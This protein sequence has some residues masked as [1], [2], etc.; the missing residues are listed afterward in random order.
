M[1]IRNSLSHLFLILFLTLCLVAFGAFGCGDDDDDDDTGNLPP[2]DDDD[3]DDDDDSAVSPVSVEIVGNLEM[4]P[5]TTTVEYSALV[6]YS[7]DTT[8]TNPADLEW[9][10]ENEDVAT[11]VDGTVTGVA[12]GATTL[13]AAVG[14]TKVSGSMDIFVGPDVYL[15]DFFTNTFDA[16][17]RV[18]KTYT[19]GYID[20]AGPDEM[21]LNDIIFADGKVYLANSGDFFLGTEGDEGVFEVDTGN[22]TT[23]LI[24]IAVTGPWATANDNGTIYLTGNG[25]SKLGIYNSTKGVSFVDLPA[26]CVP[27]EL[28][29]ANGKVYI[30]CTGFDFSDF[31]Y[32]NTVAVYDPST[33][34]VS[35]VTLETGENPGFII[36]NSDETAV[37][38]VAVGDYATTFGAINKIDTTTDTVV[39][40]FALGGTLGGADLAPNGYLFVLDGINMYVID[41]SDDSLVRDESD[42]IVVGNTGDYLAGIHAHNDVSEIYV[43]AIDYVLFANSVFVINSDT[44]EMVHTYDLSDP[45]SAPGRL[46]SW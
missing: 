16:I 15:Y 28:A 42:P 33:K 30:S 8:Q 24:P 23:N 19:V 26:N 35:T 34:G 43:S 41:T 9:A 38:V 45:M 2:V 18:A 31:S 11:V 36:P 12:N 10:I 39:D 20:L 27:G 25:D 40:S 32:G 13:T 14:E 7:D 22:M 17:D 6:T 37:Y 1:F 4:I 46:T 21:L 3:D 29:V 44:F 5:A